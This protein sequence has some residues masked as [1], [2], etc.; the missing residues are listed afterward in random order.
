MRSQGTDH[1][2]TQ[3]Q[4]WKIMGLSQSFFKNND[5]FDEL[6]MGMSSDYKIAMEQGCTMIRVGSTVFGKRVIKHWKNN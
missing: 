1:R 6:S 2:E 5:S 3:K 4:G